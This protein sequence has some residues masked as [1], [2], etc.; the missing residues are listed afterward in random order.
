MADLYWVG[1][2]STDSMLLA[3]WRTA[4]RGTSTPS[5][6]TASDTW[7][8]TDMGVSDCLHNDVSFGVIEGLMWES[9]YDT[10]D[11][12]AVGDSKNVSRERK[13]QHSVI[14][15]VNIITKKIQ[16]D[17]ILKSNT[18]G[19]EITMGG[20]PLLDN[21][22]KY[23]TLGKHASFPTPHM[24]LKLGGAGAN[25][26]LDYG[27][28]PFIVHMAGRWITSH[29]DPTYANNTK[30]TMKAIEIRTGSTVSPLT[31]STRRD[32]DFCVEI[33][34]D[35][36]IIQTFL[37]QIDEISFGWG[38]LAI[39]GANS[40]QFYIPIDKEIAH[41]TGT[42]AFRITYG[43]YRCLKNPDVA[44]SISKVRAGMKMCVNHFIVDEGAILTGGYDSSGG[45]AEIECVSMPE[46]KGS[47]TNFVQVNDGLYRAT[48]ISENKGG[49]LPCP[50]LGYRYGGTGL[51][52]LGTSGQVL[53]TDG[54]T[55]YWATPSGGGGGSGTVT[56][57]DMTVPTGFVISG[58]P[59]TT[60]GTLA[61]SYASGYSLPTDASQANWDT[62]YGWGNHASAG[63]LTSIPNYLA[64]QSGAPTPAPT[65]TDVHIGYGNP[66][67]ETL[68]IRTQYGYLNL[69][70]R[71]AGYCHFYTDR[72]FFYFN[73][74]LQFDGGDGVYAYNG[75]FWVR[76]DDASATPTERLTIKGAQN[77]TRIGIKQTNPQTELDVS[78]IIRQTNATNAIV[79]ADANGDLGSL[80]V[81]SGLSLV[82]STLSA[83]GGGGGGL[84][85]S[86]GYPLFKHDQNPTFTNFNPFRLLVNGDNIEL[87]TASGGDDNHDV[88]VFTPTDTDTAPVSVNITAIGDVATNTGREYIF[89][90]Q[91]NRMMPTTYVGGANTAVPIY[92]VESMREI[93]PAPNLFFGRHVLE[94][95]PGLG[96]N[97][98][99]VVD[100]G[101]HT[102]LNASP[103][104]GHEAGEPEEPTPVRI[105]LL[106]DHQ[107]LEFRGTFT[108]NYRLM[109]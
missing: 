36:S 75:D 5:A 63:Y 12:V 39:A 2:V 91:G 16:L 66:Y 86:G 42:G 73:R 85:P 99:R 74:P 88:S 56:S 62:A 28:Y 7:I 27:N 21:N 40:G 68:S 107:L 61:V 31:T 60:A 72:N 11:E 29:R 54:A 78:G 65:N 106:T 93:V 4:Y 46:I 41:G 51:S 67:T 92:F 44:N 79:H 59:I 89:Y 103:S 90:G 1:D 71:N 10:V 8:F 108:A 48:D 55:I 58:N 80:T 9:K 57:V 109:A 22:N 52:T 14:I 84:A 19:V 76:T 3:N 20:T 13:Y 43:A 17:G 24:K 105:L 18:T 81:G 50:V 34:G 23:I 49:I 47:M 87:G 35:A 98:V 26:Y 101:I 30:I 95:G 70:A 94:I 25:Y 96:L 64:F 100:A 97:N 82:G 6:I 102:V 15:D 38:T 83:T 77:E 69:G 37:C 104:G 45:I 33:T 32:K 53:T